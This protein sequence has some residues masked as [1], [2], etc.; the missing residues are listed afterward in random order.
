MQKAIEWNNFEEEII[1]KY[2][3]SLYTGPS[4]VLALNPFRILIES[5]NSIFG[6]VP[7]LLIIVLSLAITGKEKSD[8]SALFSKFSPVKTNKLIFSKLLTS[9]LLALLY[10]IFAVFFSLIISK[11][12]GY[13]WLNGQYEIYRIF[14]EDGSFKY[15]LAYELLLRIILIFL[16]MTTFFTSVGIYIS[17]KN[18]NFVSKIFIISTIVIILTIL[19]KSF[20]SF[21]TIFNPI[22]SLN[23]KEN[24]LGYIIYTNTSSLDGQNYIY[25]KGQLQ[26]IIYFFISFIFLHLSQKNWWNIKNEEK[27]SF[28]KVESLFN[29]EKVKILYNNSFKTLILATLSIFLVIFISLIVKDIKMD[30]ANQH[31][32]LAGNFELMLNNLKYNAELVADLYGDDVSGDVKS[33]IE[34]YENLYNEALKAYSYYKEGNGKDYYNIMLTELNYDEN[35]NH[36]SIEGRNA[37]IATYFESKKLYEYLSENNIKPETISY[38]IF[39][40]AYEKLI[41]EAFLFK[42]DNIYSHSALY[43]PRRLERTYPID[44]LII[45]IISMVAFGAYTFDKE[46]GNQIELLYTQ[47]VTRRKYH[48]NK[49]ASSFLVGLLT[50]AIIFA[51]IFLFGLISG[52]LGDYR[53]PVLEYI[54]DIDLE[55][56]QSNT[57]SYFKL[58]PIWR[59]DIKLFVIYVFQIGFLASLVSFVSIFVK[60]KMKA[61]GLSLG[62][63]ALFTYI[64]STINSPIKAFSPFT[65]MRASTLANG[66]YIINSGLKTNNVY[67]GLCVLLISS[68]IL[69]FAGSFL[70]K[71][72]DV[73]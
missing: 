29:F 1:K 50:L 64:Q 21:R 11:M 61:L 18:G 59:Y 57:E 46:H 54:K 33:K 65:Y 10:S 7:I 39:I 41:P 6:I 60:E 70:V 20:D 8:G 3:T 62:L 63:T 27:A 66:S 44:L 48:I 43:L 37:G 47:P 4:T 19:T 26:Y 40:S 38:T 56:I 69:F 68:I 24:I 5:T 22:Y 52:G 23:I 67:I 35:E 17:S 53:F 9:I 45:G 32:R 51:F 71:K 73:K 30:K 12:Y 36:D 49:V 72:I 14:T 16:F 31:T 55:T 58:I 13:S 2:N 42:E 25:S 15:Y 34:K 28:K